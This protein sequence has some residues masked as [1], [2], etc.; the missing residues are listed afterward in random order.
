MEEEQIGDT[1]SKEESDKA[2]SF[3]NDYINTCDCKDLH[4][5]H[6]ELRIIYTVV[7]ELLTAIEQGHTKEHQLN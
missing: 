4:D 5:V 2:I 6:W 3:I 7:C 1:M